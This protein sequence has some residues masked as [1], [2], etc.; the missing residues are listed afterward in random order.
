MIGVSMG[1]RTTADA[2]AA[3]DQIAGVADI[4]ELRLDFMSDYNLSSL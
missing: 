4:A 2:V 1:V 3:L